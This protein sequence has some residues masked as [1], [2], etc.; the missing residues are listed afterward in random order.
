MKKVEFNCQLIKS[1]WDRVTLTTTQTVLWHL[2]EP[3]VSVLSAVYFCGYK[4]SAHR[5]NNENETQW[6][7]KGVQR[8]WN[9]GNH[10]FAIFTQV[11]H[12][13]RVWF[14]ADDVRMNLFRSAYH[15]FIVMKLVNIAAARLN[16]NWLNKRGNQRLTSAAQHCQLPFKLPG[17]LNCAVQL[18]LG[19]TIFFGKRASLSKSRLNKSVFI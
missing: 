16:H 14:N 11:L 18:K 12:S 8:G 15:A 2:L 19:A 3:S 10:N 17:W 13:V 9:R 7:T 1:L 6:K 5:K 4:P